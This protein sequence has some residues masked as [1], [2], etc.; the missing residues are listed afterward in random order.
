VES[1]AAGL[2]AVV[3][4]NVGVLEHLRPAD[5]TVVALDPRLWADACAGLLEAATG[6]RE[7]PLARLQSLF[8]P[9]QVAQEWLVV[10]EQLSAPVPEDPAS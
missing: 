7:R 9:D 4:P 6:P 8:H 5:A 3:C 10:Y 1:V 2:P